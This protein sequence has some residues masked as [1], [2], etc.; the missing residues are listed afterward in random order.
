METKKNQ[1][2]TQ[3][4]PKPK[5]EEERVAVATFNLKKFIMELMGSFA[6]VYFGNW[7]EIF[8][9]LGKSNL[10]TVSL[11][12]GLV[13][14]ILTWIGSDISGAHFNPITTLSMVY[15]RMIHWSTAVLY[16]IFQFLGGLIA[17]AVIFLQVPEKMFSELKYPSSL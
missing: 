16:W 11:S 5:Q 14:T 12:I 2:E 8:N 7:A 9:E 10:I 6:I 17:G 13:M 1:P 4:K 15:L 3:V